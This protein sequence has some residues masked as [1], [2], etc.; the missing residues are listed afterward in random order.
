MRRPDTTSKSLSRAVRKM[1][2]SAADIARSSR[3][4]VKPPSGS[5]P[6]PMTQRAAEMP[7]MEES[8]VN[9]TLKQFLHDFAFTCAAAFVAGGLVS[10]V[11]VTVILL[12]VRE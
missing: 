6:R 11:A 2:G 12:F 10:A 8:K 3:H 5:S 1:I 9:V 4:S 7:S